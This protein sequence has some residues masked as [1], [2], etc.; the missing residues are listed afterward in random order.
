LLK[1]I[2]DDL[3]V[4]GVRLHFYRTG[5]D[6]PPFVLLHG[7]ADS[8][9]TWMPVAE[10]LSVEYDVIM[11]DAQGHGQSDR[12]TPAYHPSEMA[13]QMA[14]LIQLLKLERPA[15]MGHS[16]GADA[17]VELALQNP[18]LP[19]AIVLEDP[20]WLEQPLPGQE[21]AEQLKK[22]SKMDRAITNFEQKSLSELLVEGRRSNPTWSETD[23]VLF[24]EAKKQFDTRLFS[25]IRDS[26][27]DKPV[28]YPQFVTEINCPTLLIT[29]QRGRVSPATA[30]KAAQMWKSQYP[31]KWVR[32]MEAGHNI[33][34][35]QPEKFK[36]AV[37]QFLKDAG[38]CDL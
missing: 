31:F 36:T 11:P 34:R 35:D 7:S 14:V 32:I 38:R 8:G 20:I 27:K 10:W 13:K 29:A 28:T 1:Y 18:G 19:S 30:Q 17:V 24:A 25:N 16:M 26:F 15:L 21:A 6:K 9:L 22:S 23:L 4:N 12:L 5:G 33:R 2:E 37:V 3:I